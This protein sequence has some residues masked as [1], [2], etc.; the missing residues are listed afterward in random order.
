MPQVNARQEGELLL[1]LSVKGQEVFRDTKAVSVLPP[2]KAAGAGDV[3]VYDP[4][5]RLKAFLDAAGSRTPRSPVWRICRRP[6][7]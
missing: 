7:C 2:A 6:R 5:G 4:K 3:A 1:M